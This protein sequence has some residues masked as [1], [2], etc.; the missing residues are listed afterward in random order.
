MI[1]DFLINATENQITCYTAI[2]VLFLWIFSECVIKYKKKLKLKVG[3]V[4]LP[5]FIAGGSSIVLWWMT[6]PVALR[7][8]TG[9]LPIWFT[10]IELIWIGTFICV[11]ALFIL[12]LVGLVS[13]ERWF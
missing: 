8:F 13:P 3:F 11:I 2:T 4:I 7:V 9:E 10:S 12:T 1:F 5:L 6:I